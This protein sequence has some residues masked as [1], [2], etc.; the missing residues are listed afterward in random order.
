MTSLS[1][2]EGALVNA[3]D[4]VIED[5]NYAVNQKA[6]SSVLVVNY[7]TNDKYERAKRINLET[8]ARYISTMTLNVKTNDKLANGTSSVCS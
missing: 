6:H 7:P 4:Q 2:E 3:I 5:G 8:G 1:S